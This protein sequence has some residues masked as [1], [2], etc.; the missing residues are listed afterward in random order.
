MSA[1]YDQS[2]GS[3]TFYRQVDCS[4]PL[5]PK[6]P[7]KES[8]W[9]MCSREERKNIALRCHGGH[10]LPNTSEGM[11]R[12]YYEKSKKHDP[13]KQIPAQIYTLTPGTVDTMLDE[14]NQMY[15]VI[16]RGHFLNYFRELKK[17]QIIIRSD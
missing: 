5:P 3:P 6:T 17:Q 1:S 10:L 8:V 15:E 11:E 9:T 12:R 4:Q 13:Y 16:T 7:N 2:T 14:Y